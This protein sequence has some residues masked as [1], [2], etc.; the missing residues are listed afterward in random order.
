MAKPPKGRLP[1]GIS[2]RSGRFYLKWKDGHGHWQRQVCAATR[3]GQAEDFLDE[4]RM[5]A[6]R[7]RKGL[8]PLPGLSRM[9]LAE[10]AKWWLKNICS[11]R[12]YETAEATLRVHVIDAAIGKLLLGAVTAD[13]LTERFDG[14]EREGYAPGSINQIRA[15]IRAL[16]N[17][18]RREK[19]YIGANP[20]ADT[21]IRAVRR[22]VHLTLKPTEVA[23]LLKAVPSQWR[24]FFAT[25]IY[26]GMRKGELC[27]LPKALVDLEQGTVMVAY[28]Y[29]S[30]TTKG[31]TALAVPIAKPLLHYL[32]QAIEESPTELVFPGVNGK[33][34]MQDCA[35]LEILKSSLKRAGLVDGYEHSCRRCNKGAAA[36]GRERVVFQY[37]DADLRRCPH[38]NAK[39]WPAPKARRMV[40]HDLRHSTATMLLQARVPMQHVQRILR[41]AQITTTI[42]TYGHLDIEDLRWAVDSIGVPGGAS[43][44]TPTPTPGAPNEAAQLL[45]RL[46]ELLDPAKS[47]AP[48]VQGL[49]VVK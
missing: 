27:G 21:R 28:S 24:G 44:P 4:L 32:K 13:T 22:R 17:H 3:V 36:E 26:T 35:P 5:A 31:N 1:P 47:G 23:R 18:L 45:A 39:L 19:L 43:G 2:F 41:H 40:F 25:A 10:A 11:K 20:V 48:V 42:D 38:C 7:Q 8:D 14:L 16:Y 15:R 34:R 46:T 49:R 37:A 12:S 29:D 30:N 6:Y 9:T 33:R